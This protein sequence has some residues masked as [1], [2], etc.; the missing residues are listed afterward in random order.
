MENTEN[1]EFF[2][3]KYLKYKK[4]YLILKEQT[5]GGNKKNDNNG[6]SLQKILPSYYVMY[7]ILDEATYNVILREIKERILSIKQIESF[8]RGS[9]LKL[10]EYNQIIQFINAP[11]ALLQSNTSKQIKRIMGSS[12]GIHSPEYILKKTDNSSFVTLNKIEEPF[13]YGM[14]YNDESFI[15]QINTTISTNLQKKNPPDVNNGQGYA[16]ITSTSNFYG[17]MMFKFT[18]SECKFIEA[19][20]LSAN[21][22]TLDVIK[23]PFFNKPL[24]ILESK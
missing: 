4:N 14:I 11:D 19:Y 18:K 7:I 13:R 3:E 10:G 20:K 15:T 24:K 6:M 17:I 8:I 9:A 16:D 5:S 22:L 1:S 21:T 23:N 12:I 2:R